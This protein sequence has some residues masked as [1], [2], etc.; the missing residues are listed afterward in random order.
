MPSAAAS[1][2]ASSK[3]I[4]GALPPSSRWTRLRSAAAELGDLH[5]GAHRAGDRDHLRGRVLD[6]RAAG[7]AVAADDVEHARAAGTPGPARRAASIEAGV[8]S[9]RLEHDRVAGGQ[10]RA[11]SSR[12]SSSA[13]SST[14]VTWPTTPIGSRR[15]HEVWSFMY[16]PADA[17]LE[18]PRGAGEEPEAGRARGGS[19]SRHRQ[20]ERLAGV[21][22][23]RPRRSRRRAPRSRRRS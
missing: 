2:S 13:G 3:T 9:L 6:Q 14:G 19:S 21:L 20:P 11:R 1:M 5:A 12:S 16:S 23:T 7:V 18:H 22:A 4:T 15:T 10:R 8:V 17:A